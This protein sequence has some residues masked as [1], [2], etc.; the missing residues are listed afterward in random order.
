MSFDVFGA[1]DLGAPSTSGSGQ[2]PFDG[3][4]HVV[5]PVRIRARLQVQGMEEG[6]G[7]LQR[8]HFVTFTAL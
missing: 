7:V 5:T 3:M 8:T 1:N 6:E 4:I 2:L